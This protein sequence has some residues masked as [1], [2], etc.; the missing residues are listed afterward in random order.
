MVDHGTM[1]R[2]RLP[3]LEVR[4]P[5]RVPRAFA[6]RAHGHWFRGLRECSG[7]RL[8]AGGLAS[9]PTAYHHVASGNTPS[10]E[11]AGLQG[12]PFDWRRPRG[13][14][15]TPWAQ[16]VVL[17]GKCSGPLPGPQLRVAPGPFDRGMDCVAEAAGATGIGRCSRGVR[18]PIGR[19]THC[20][21]LRRPIPSRRG[22]EA[23]DHYNAP[24]QGLP[25]TL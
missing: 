8:Q 3:V 19:D 25:A 10:I 20:R 16:Q 21:D 14:Y 5:F 6:C 15:Q 4:E 7:A 2:G 11:G 24:G 12:A 13:P 9:G 23:S 1:I 22:Y 18:W 17:R